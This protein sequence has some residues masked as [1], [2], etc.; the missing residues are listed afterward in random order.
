MIIINKHSYKITIV[1]NI[2][3]YSMCYFIIYHIY[4]Y[5]NINKF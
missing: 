3:K 2:K 1:K 5:I 4:I